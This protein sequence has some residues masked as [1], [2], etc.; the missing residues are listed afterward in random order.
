MSQIADKVMEKALMYMRDIE[1]IADETPSAMIVDFA[2][3]KYSDLRNFPNY[4]SEE[5]IEKDIEKHISTIAMAVVDLFM[6]I[7]AEGEKEHKE[8]NITRVYE[9]AYISGSIFADVIPFVK[10]F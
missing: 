10:V 9:N 2:I 4:F 5:E 7:G 8:K 3:E 6:K 1:E